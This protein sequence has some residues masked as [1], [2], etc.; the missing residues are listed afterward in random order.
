MLKI[1][2]TANGEIVFTL[3]GRLEADNLSDLST[4]IAAEWIA[5]ERE[6]R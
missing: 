2:R 5:R 4:L 6:Q 3:T 1:Q